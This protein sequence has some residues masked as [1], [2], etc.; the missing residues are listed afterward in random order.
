MHQ[1][2]R[3]LPLIIDGS[4]DLYRWVRAAL[5]V[6]GSSLNAWCQT[7]GINRQTVEKALKGER[8]SRAAIKIRERLVAELTEVE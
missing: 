1:I 2:K 7:N 6:R 8:L 5:I 4:E 3:T